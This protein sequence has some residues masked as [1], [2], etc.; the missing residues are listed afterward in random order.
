MTKLQAAALC[1]VLT[2]CSS[3]AGPD[4]AVP[5]K[6][7]E[8]FAARTAYLGDN[9]RVSSLVSK[10]VAGSVGSYTLELQTARPPLG[11]TVNIGRPVTPSLKTDF[12]KDATLLLGL[13]GNVDEVTFAAGRET[14]TFTATSASKTAGFDVKKLGK[15]QQVL[16]DYLRKTAD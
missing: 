3:A 6:A 2:G 13:I 7:A 1:L 14:H 15:D 8:L 10:V 11:L 12:S 4:S 16:A 9:P 5:S